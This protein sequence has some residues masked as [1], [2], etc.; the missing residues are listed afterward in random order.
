MILQFAFALLVRQLAGEKFGGSGWCP[1]D[2]YEKPDK[3]RDCYYPSS[4]ADSDR[5]SNMFCSYGTPDETIKLF[6][7]YDQANMYCPSGS[8]PKRCEKCMDW[9][10]G[11]GC[12]KMR[13]EG[14]RYSKWVKGVPTIFHTKWNGGIREGDDG[15]SRWT[16]SNDWE[17]IRMWVG[18][19]KDGDDIDAIEMFIEAP[20]PNDSLGEKMLPE[21]FFKDIGSQFTKMEKITVRANLWGLRKEDIPW[22]LRL[23]ELD[24]SG[25]SFNHTGWP[26]AVFD[27][28]V[29]WDDMLRLNL[30]GNGLGNYPNSLL[31]DDYAPW[32]NLPGLVK[33]DLSHNMIDNISPC[34]FGCT[35]GQYMEIF[36][37]DL[38]TLDLSYNQLND[39]SF[40]SVYLY[41]FDRVEVKSSEVFK[42][43]ENLKTIDMS[44][45]KLTYLP[46]DIFTLPSLKSLKSVDLRN[47]GMTCL[48][49][50][51][52][53]GSWTPDGPWFNDNSD[54]ELCK[55]V[56]P[57]L[58]NDGDRSLGLSALTGVSNI[59]MGVPVVAVVGAGIVMAFKK[60]KSEVY[61]TAI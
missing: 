8:D 15:H 26:F 37:P 49:K 13:G 41:G 12:A 6:Y 14:F 36:N 44:N 45:N 34:T 40:S 22:Q 17:P 53:G 10:L 51:P 61:D 42:G 29:L 20:N 33:L 47:N 56:R 24:L 1:S 39:K 46:P 7:T 32:E 57:I 59:W 19:E 3:K 31:G 9:Q 58:I 55:E 60:P 5:I 43:L 52:K 50:L 4:G 2:D 48:P 38:K 28:A 35:P 16:Y 11:V 25:N 27:S 54:L 30:S 21:N 23:Q 18:C